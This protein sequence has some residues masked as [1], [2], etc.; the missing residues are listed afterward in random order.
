MWKYVLAWFPMVFLAI[1]NGALREAWYGKHLSE[2]RAH[3]VSTAFG[4]LLFGVYIWMLLRIWKP[5][6]ANQAL[7]IGFLWLCLTV[8]FEFLFFHYVMG[9]PWSSILHDYNLFAGRVWVVILIWVTVA[10]YVFYRMQL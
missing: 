6:S 2:L 3:Q 8:A 9:H 7:V 5:T 4:V 10:P 1:A